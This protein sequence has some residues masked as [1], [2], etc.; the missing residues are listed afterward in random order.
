MAYYVCH[1]CGH[2]GND[3]TLEGDHRYPFRSG[4]THI[5]ES[6]WVCNRQKGAKTAYAFAKWL[7]EHPE[8]MQPGVPF[9]DSNRRL[10]VRRELRSRG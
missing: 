4:G 2:S 10:F 1:Y 5:V 6:C 3:N 7:S 9:W 8:Q